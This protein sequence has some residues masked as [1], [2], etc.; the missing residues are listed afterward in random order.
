MCSSDLQKE[1]V[2]P[3]GKTLKDVDDYRQGYYLIIEHDGAG[4][5]EQYIIY[6]DA[7]LPTA[8]VTAT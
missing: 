6:S 1:F 3:K 7:E 4:N 8:R 2:I 5:V